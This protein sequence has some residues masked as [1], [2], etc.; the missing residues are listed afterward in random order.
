MDCTESLST[1]LTS[2]DHHWNIPFLKMSGQSK[3][4][5]EQL[6]SS[7]GDSSSFKKVYLVH[8]MM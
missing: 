7:I 4:M 2:T 6:W 3:R 5:T 8:L 1:K